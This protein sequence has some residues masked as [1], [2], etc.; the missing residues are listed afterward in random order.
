[1]VVF[2]VLDFFPTENMEI[3]VNEGLCFYLVR[4]VG[5][6]HINAISNAL[7]PSLTASISHN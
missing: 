4:S 6:L 5:K 3:L 7:K 1:M 2:I